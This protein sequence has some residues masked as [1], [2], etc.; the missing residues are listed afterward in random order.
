MKKHLWQYLRTINDQLAIL[1][2]AAG[3]NLDIECPYPWTPD[4]WIDFL[5]ADPEI[6]DSLWPVYKKF[7]RAMEDLIDGMDE[8]G[9][10]YNDEIRNMKLL[11]KEEFLVKYG[12]L[13]EDAKAIHAGIKK[14]VSSGETETIRGLTD[15]DSKEKQ[16]ILWDTEIPPLVT[17]I[18]IT[19]LMITET[20]TID[21]YNTEIH[22]TLSG[23]DDDSFWLSNIVS[24][25]V[26]SYKAGKVGRRCAAPDCDIFFTPS[27]RRQD[28]AYHSSRCQNRVFMR[29]ARSAQQ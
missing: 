28:Q 20:H 16:S 17:K 5:N 10:Q 3:M 15:Q 12:D 4:L 23:A 27:P 25:L 22:L 6:P 24:G 2:L 18:R 1:P 29:K 9:T 11:S 13:R 7:A 21:K 19:N 8:A 14:A 26:L